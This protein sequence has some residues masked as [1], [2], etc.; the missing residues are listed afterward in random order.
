MSE[1]LG[2]VLVEAAGLTKVYGDVRALDGFD[3]SVRAGEIVC[4]I[5]PSGS[6]KSTLLRSVNGLEQP[7][8]GALR[9]LGVDVLD[10]DT[11]MDALRADVGMVFQQFNLFP[12]LDVL[13]N[14]TLAPTLVRRLPP[15]AARE[16]AL[17]LL[18]RVGIRDK[19]HERPDTLSG[20]QQQ[21]V[22]IARALAMQPRVGPGAGCAPD[23]T[24][25]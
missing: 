6:G 2:E 3:L 17:A 21:R 12:H 7:E 16:R 11:D 5:G 4:L 8:S 22:A 25:R 1:P 15:H 9:V 14:V 20:G 10:P 23:T 13:G 19:A 18:E 24:G